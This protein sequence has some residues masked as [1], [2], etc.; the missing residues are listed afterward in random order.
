MRG[1]GLSSLWIFN[2]LHFGE[3]LSLSVLEDILLMMAAILGGTILQKFSGPYS[4]KIGHKK[5][6][7]A[8]LVA[9]TLLYLILI[10]SSFVQTSPVYYSITFFA[11]TLSSSALQPSIY[12]IVS[13]E[14]EVKTKE[15]ST[16]RVGNNIGWRLEPAM[17]G[18]CIP[19]VCSNGFSDLDT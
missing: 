12:S 9:L 8:S 13:A 18:F 16:L 3:A 2:A 10:L 6:V 17:G 1:L 4:D 15:F 19:F 5:A 14:S 11:L 7:V